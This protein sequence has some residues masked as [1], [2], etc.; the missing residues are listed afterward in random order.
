MYDP[1]QSRAASVD[2][3]GLELP[4]ETEP[5]AKSQSG[6]GFARLDYD[7]APFRF[8]ESVA[9]E[10][11]TW[12]DFEKEAGEDGGCGCRSG[13]PCR[14]H[15]T[16]SDEWFAESDEGEAFIGHGEGEG[17]PQAFDHP[18]MSGFAT[19]AP[20]LDRNL[21]SYSSAVAK[22]KVALFVPPAAE[23][24]ESAD[25]LFYVHGLLSPCGVP[26]NLPQ[27]IV[28][29][30]MF[31]LADAVAAAPRPTILVVPLF[32]QSGGAAWS[33]QGLD[34][35]ER[36]NAFMV[37]ALAEVG[38]KFGGAA[39]RLDQL[40]IA[41]HSRAF[42]VLN[43]LAGEAAK[44]AMASGALARLAQYWALDASYGSFPLDKY[45]ALAGS[46]PALGVH[47]VYRTCSPTDKFSAATSGGGV[48]LWPIANHAKIRHCDVP[49]IY[50]PLLLREMA[51]PGARSDELG[52]VDR[53]DPAFENE[54]PAHS[55]SNCPSGARTVLAASAARALRAVNNAAAFV[56]S[57]Y[58]RP[59]RMHPQMRALLAKHFHTSDHDD[60][61]TILSNLMGIAKALKDGVRFE[62]RTECAA[63]PGGKMCGYAATSQWFGG[64]G[65]V[66]VCFDPRPGHCRFDREPERTRDRIVIHEVAHRYKGIDD[67]AYCWKAEYNRLTAGQALD[68]ADSYA[69][70]ALDMLSVP[71][72][73]APVREADTEA[74]LEQSDSAFEQSWEEADAHA[75]AEADYFDETL[76]GELEAASELERGDDEE[77]DERGRFDAFGDMRDAEWEDESHESEQPFSEAGFEDE[78]PAPSPFLAMGL[79]A[80]EAK[81]LEITATLET[82]GPFKFYGLTGNFDGQGLSFGL[83]NWT[84]GTGS[85]Q[86]LLLAFAKEEPAGWARIFGGDADAFLKAVQADKKVGHKFAVE[87][88]NDQKVVKTSKGHKTVWS[89][90]EPWKSYFK[91]LS[92][93][94]AF[95]RIQVRFV[96]PMLKKADEYCRK[97]GFKSEMAFAFMFDAVS[98]HGQWWLT[99]KFIVG[100]KKVPT[101]QLLIDQRLSFLKTMLPAW[102]LTERD[103]LNIIADV[104]AA[105][106]SPKWAENVRIRKHWFTGGPAPR[107]KALLDARIPSADRPYATAPDARGE[108]FE[109][110]EGEEFEDY[111]AE[112]L[113][114][115]E[116]REEQEAR[117][118]DGISAAIEQA[119][120]AGSQEDRTALA[121]AL[122]ANG[123]SVAEWF[124]GVVPDATFLGVGIRASG[125]SVSGVHREFLAIL[126]KAETALL[127]KYPGKTAR[128]LGQDMGIAQ[129]AGLRPP[130]KATGGGQ[131]SMHC[132]GMGIDINHDTNPFIGNQKAKKAKGEKV[133]KFE[134]NRSPY[135]IDR[136]MQLIHGRA[137]RV[138]GPKRLV[139][140]TGPA[141]VARAW[142]IHHEA[143]EALARYL[144]LA[145]NLEGSELAQLVLQARSAGYDH[146]LEWWQKWIKTDRSVI[147]YWDFPNHPAPWRKG[148]M[149]LP[150]DLVIALAEAGMLW[151]G[152]YN[153]AKDIMH[154]D[155]RGGTIK[156]R[157]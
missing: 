151:G 96:R 31:K 135:I 23:T 125:G 57:A 69:C 58:G 2:P 124:G 95:R 27:G 97:F 14:Q 5:P 52:E 7:E 39:R 148:Y 54:A 67:H 106:S 3:I 154:F 55:F 47:I 65:A 91:A 107:D 88:M 110:G 34:K 119:Q 19:E 114:E 6:G 61:R 120:R 50:I 70:F 90:K 80:A 33:A 81:A 13:A 83:V 87:I 24:R 59:D 105:T 103:Q 72:A 121:H 149:D 109:S 36:F 127:A 74:W 48:K 146:P 49:R 139:D 1:R 16:P 104:L 93:H 46:K 12:L 113:D 20:A 92:E 63:D 76:L 17:A 75:E 137:L 128:Q 28:S 132:Y 60:L 157:A 150:R 30:D 82:G 45:R 29:S 130:K 66:N 77:E 140:G 122:Q 118:K 138:E 100:G 84:I 143:S 68:N 79:T 25:V 15:E 102:S 42:G 37:E 153:G 43:P 144:S 115:A 18:D 131:I 38:K 40:A 44:P 117:R 129:I 134:Y 99:K 147:K 11:L 78:A 64:F 152:V 62:C 112:P 71:R 73:A 26:K 51:T 111:Q 9:E 145:D 126:K 41:G 133:S 32:Q 116:F 4:F 8:A 98:S 141:A 108:T 10:S 142:D 22:A 86:P 35:A 123:T 155:Y 101:R 85:L 94:D 53:E 21:W 89:I 156:A 56:G 136:A